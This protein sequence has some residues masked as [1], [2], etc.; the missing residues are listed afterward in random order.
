LPKIFV[1]AANTEDEVRYEL[2]TYVRQTV[3]LVEDRR[4]EHC[5]ARVLTDRGGGVG[6]RWEWAIFDDCKAVRRVW[7]VP[8]DH[9]QASCRLAFYLRVSP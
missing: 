3:W 6:S 8:A 5:T 2:R 1:R 9:V 7:S 4:V